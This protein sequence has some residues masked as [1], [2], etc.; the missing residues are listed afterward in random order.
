MNLVKQNG[1]SIGALA[2]AAIDIPWSP[3]RPPYL[4]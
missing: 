1:N 2:I 3:H 4:Q